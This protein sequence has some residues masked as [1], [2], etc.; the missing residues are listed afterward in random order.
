V[1]DPAW[2]P[3][4]DGS[5]LSARIWLPESAEEQPVPAILE[6]LPYR[7]DD[8]TAADDARRHPYVAARGYACARVDMRGSGASDGV[9]LD[10]YSAQEHDDALEIIAWLAEQPWCTG[11]VGMTG[12]SWSGFNSLQVAAR[13]PPALKAII[14]ACS[15]DDRYADDVHYFGGVPLACYL[16]TWACALMGFNARP[17]DPLIAGDRWRDLWLERL[18]HNPDLAS[19]WLEHQSRDEYWRHGSISEDYGAIECAVLAVGGWADAYVDAILR[20][21]ANLF[22]PRMGLIGPWGHLWPQDGRPGPAIGFLQ[23]SL[24]WWDHWLKGKDTGIMEE[25]MLRAFMQESVAPA[26]DYA[27]RPGRWIAERSWPR[28]EPPLTLYLGDGVLESNPTPAAT[29]AHCSVQTVGLDGGAFCAYGNPADFATD[30]RRDDALSLSFDTEPL[31][32]RI[33]LLGQPAVRLTVA[34]DRPTAFVSARLCDVAPDG[35]STLVTR[36][37]LNLCHHGGHDRPQPLVAGGRLEVTIPLRS[38]AYALPAG[39][40]LRLALSTCYWPWMWPSPEPVTITVTT[41]TASQLLLPM[42][43]P[44]PE[45]PQPRPFEPP[46]HA[47][48]LPV[49]QLRARRPEHLI[50]YDPASG[51]LTVRIRRDFGGGQRLPSG[52]EYSEYDPT[53]LTIHDG[54]PLSAKVVCERRIEMRRGPWRTRI[55]LSSTMTASAH[56]YLL[57]TV[58][59]AYERDTRVHSRTFTR[60]I[61]RNC[62]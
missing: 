56:E 9:L 23:E 16:L 29:R 34:S 13:R 17:P 53:T 40:R 52:M 3:L 54:D 37:V 11:A 15:T 18:E 26:P 46:A 33:E 44:S 12:I 60:A 2:I 20:M 24:R 58:I 38:T 1:I 28:A 5:R 21:L 14:T 61:P 32:N 4:S 43:P 36:G 45:E 6:Y 30:Q 31:Q 62:T 39:H 8:V 19:L 48:P 22:C 25:P 41:G 7:K 51:E 55:E 50:G 42:R 27:E 59:D 47:P 57:S 10:E 35:T 49:V